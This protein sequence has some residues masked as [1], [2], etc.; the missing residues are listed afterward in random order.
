[1]RRPAE[2]VTCGEVFDSAS[3][4]SRGWVRYRKS[5]SAECR[6]RGPLGRV[7]VEEV[8]FLLST[9]MGRLEI[10][11]VLGVAAASVARVMYR[12]GRP[13]L[14]RRVEVPWAERRSV[15]AGRPMAPATSRRVA[16]GAERGGC[17]CRDGSEDSV[18]AERRTAS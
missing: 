7:T 2:C 5:C 3:R 1:V 15:S 11:G 9:G 18:N 8:E 10:A 4:D 17:G 16:C 13:D 14:A 6:Q 12:L